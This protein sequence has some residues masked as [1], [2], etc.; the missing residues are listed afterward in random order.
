MKFKKLNVITLVDLG[1]LKN[2]SSK[3]LKDLENEFI[4]EISN[5]KILKN[6]LEKKDFDSNLL[7]I[8]FLLKKGLKLGVIK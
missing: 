2:V 8:E 1:S 3:V 7:N 5:K 6:E 4:L